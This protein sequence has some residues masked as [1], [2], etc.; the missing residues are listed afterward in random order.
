MTHAQ[1]MT[2]SELKVIKVQGKGWLG[3]KMSKR[4]IGYAH[5]YI[6]FS[7]HSTDDLKQINELMS[8]GK[9]YLICDQPQKALEYFVELC[10]KL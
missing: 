3:T 1:Q 10:E 2:F 7:F 6:Y 5:H 8:D 9:K 4:G